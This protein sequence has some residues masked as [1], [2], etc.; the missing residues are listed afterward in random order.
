MASWCTSSNVISSDWP[1][2]SGRVVGRDDTEDT[3]GLLEGRSHL[4]LVD[5][6]NIWAQSQ[7][8]AGQVTW[9]IMEPEQQHEPNYSVGLY[10]IM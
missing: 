3:A 8:A 10:S 5:Q 2:V 9:H 6:R 4:H 7:G 1:E